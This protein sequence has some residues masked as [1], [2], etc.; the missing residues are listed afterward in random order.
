[1]TI[2]VAILASGEGSLT[3]A[4][5]DASRQGDLDVQVVAVISDQR[6]A[7]VLHR[8]NKAGIPIFIQTMSK[9]RTDWNSRLF[10]L[11]E[12]LNPDLVVSAGFMR[13]LAPEFVQR[14]KT[15]NIHPAL[16]P[17]FPGAHAVRD[18]LA[19]GASVT[20]TTV[21]WVDTGMD[22]GEVICQAKVAILA[23]DSEASLHERIKIFERRLTVSAIRE[24][25]PKLESRNV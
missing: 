7:H 25:V 2:R 17:L 5:V 1:M 6:E 15:I 10:S 9:D 23:D 4:I 18:A 16:L 8:A 11:I 22:T 14:F 13:M 21:H 20:G 19:S 24:L 3:Q 12:S